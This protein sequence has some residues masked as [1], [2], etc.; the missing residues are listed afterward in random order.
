MKTW[1]HAPSKSVTHPGIY[2]IT[3][4]TYHKAPLYRGH[5]RLELLHD[6]LLETA[7]EQGWEL[8]SWAV[9]P[10]HY[11]LV[12]RS[13]LVENASNL[14][15]GTLHRAAGKLL[16]DLDDCRGRQVWQNAWDTRLTFEKSIMARIAY[17]HRN[18]CHHGMVAEPMDYPYCSAR[19]FVEQGDRPFVESVLSFK[20]DKVNVYDPF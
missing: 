5:E 11:H 8:F 12:G 16:N 10:N 4:G 17:V 1:P 6:L 2:I 18:P 19:W 7:G 15:S 13:P 14:L 3:A 9:F 20:T